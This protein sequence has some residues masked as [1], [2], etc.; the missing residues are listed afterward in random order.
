MRLSSG[1][2]TY[3]PARRKRAFSDGTTECCSI[4]IIFH[5]IAA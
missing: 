4:R 1:Y 5:A 2:R 3:D